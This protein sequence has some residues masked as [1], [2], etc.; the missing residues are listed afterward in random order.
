[1]DN[2]P[3]TLEEATSLLDLRFVDMII[4]PDYA[5]LRELE[6]VNRSQTRSRATC[7]RTSI[8]CVSNAGR[9][10]GH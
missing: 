5:E 3:V 1:M 6:E 8:C 2:T 10:C 9:H 4:G 7:R